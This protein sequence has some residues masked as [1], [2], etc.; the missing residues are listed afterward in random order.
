MQSKYRK[1]QHDQD[2]LRIRDFLVDT[3]SLTYNPTNWR[4]E[5]W[6]YAYYFLAPMLV[7]EGVGEPDMDSF[8]KALDLW[9][10]L[11]GIWENQAGE[12]V[13]VVNIEHSD[14]THP[15]WGEA[16]LQRHPDCNF[17]LPEMLEFAEENLRNEERNLIF[18]PV[19]DYDEPLLT[20]VE[21]RGYERNDT[22]TLWDSV[23]TI[24]GEIPKPVLAEGYHLRSMADVGSDIDRRRKAFGVAF[25]HPDPR[26][27]PSRL[28]YQGLQDAPDYRKD[29]DIYVCAPDGEYASFCIAWWDN[30]NRIA[31]LEPVGTA[32]EYRRKGL[33]RAAVL[34][35]LHRVRALGAERVFVGSDQ[36]FYI[37]L[38]FE[39]TN[40]SHYWVKRF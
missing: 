23:Y 5:R 10:D 29:L 38:G 25:N 4:L 7:T 11:T 31:N 13:G 40:S 39:L 1:Y 15:G 24:Q 28:A 8:R 34:E 22:F 37:S 32:P 2:F 18:V 27:W 20:A 21:E 6:N 12:I 36:E 9:N 16:F 3:F 35:A 30:A 33:A 26:D 14:K 17:L 19:Y